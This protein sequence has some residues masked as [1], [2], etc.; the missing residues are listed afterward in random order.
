MLPSKPGV[1]FGFT[2]IELLVVIAIIAILIGLL[3]PAV[4]KVREAAARV[5]C[6]NNLKQWG[7]AMHNFHDANK[8]FPYAERNSPARQTWVMWLWPYIEQSVLSSQI[9]MN[10]Q[11]FYTPPCTVYNTMN[12]L[13]GVT[14]PL[15]SC[16]SDGNGANLDNTAG[17]TYCRARGNYVICFGPQMQ[18]TALA[19]G[20]SPGMFGEIGGSRSNPLKTR[21]TS[22][23]DGTSNTLMMSEYLKAWSHDDNDWRG[24]MYNDDGTN[25]FMTL[26]TP[27]S[28]VADVV[29]WAI[30]TSDPLMPVST[31]GAQFNAARSHHTGGVNVCM[32]DGSVHFVSDGIS[33]ATWAA[34]GTMAGGDIIGSDFNP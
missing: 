7:L 12:G 19:A 2:L 27:N 32:A 10:S 9:N 1:R 3:V 21:I 14:L 22:I 29:N 34:M 17:N 30:Q 4:Q 25:H 8:Q 28:T 16:P 5:Q 33:L 20:Q 15:M 6:Q 18:D 24:D 31:N 26:T 11:N 13:C 23:T